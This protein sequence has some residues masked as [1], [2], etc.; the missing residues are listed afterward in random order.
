MSLI[1]M[2]GNLNQMQQRLTTLTPDDM[3]KLLACAKRAAA[4]VRDLKQR[5]PRG[6]LL[7]DPDIF[8][9]AMD[10]AC[11]HVNRRLKLTQL[12]LTSDPEFIAEFATITECMSKNDNRA[13]MHFPADVHLSYA[14][15]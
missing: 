4:Y 13:C 9:I 7:L 15:N 2:T 11:A 3:Q 12:L 14:E 10:F 1:K 8:L 6:H 5:S